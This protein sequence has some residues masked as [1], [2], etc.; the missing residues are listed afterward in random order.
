METLLSLINVRRETVKLKEVLGYFHTF[1][2]MVY[3]GWV[4]V[5][6]NLLWVSRVRGDE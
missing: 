2:K 1:I 4:G 6:V 5:G 3:F